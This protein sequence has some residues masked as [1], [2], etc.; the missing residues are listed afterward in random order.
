MGYPYP[1]WHNSIEM[2]FSGGNELFGLGRL[3]IAVVIAASISYIAG[4][5]PSQTE[6]QGQVGA[7]SGYDQSSDQAQATYQDIDAKQAKQLI[8]SNKNIQIIDVREDYEYAEGR[9]PGT[10]LIPIG[11]FISRMDEVDKTKPVL[12]YC[13]V[14]S[15]SP[16]AAKVLAQSGYTEVYNLDG[17]LA[18]WPYEIER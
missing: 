10:K 5:S 17:G 2:E 7:Q 18:R 11:Q 4:C 14:S 12:V 16:S 15:R 9:I 1:V 8:D 6:Y 3:F 13:S